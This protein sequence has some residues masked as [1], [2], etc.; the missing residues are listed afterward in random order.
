MSIRDG[1]TLRSLRTGEF[2]PRGGPT[3]VGVRAQALAHFSPVSS[4]AQFFTIRSSAQP[5]L[6]ALTLLFWYSSS[7]MC[8]HSRFILGPPLF[9]P[10]PRGFGA[11]LWCACGE[12]GKQGPTPHFMI[13]R[14]PTWGQPASIPRGGGL[15]W[16]RPL[17]EGEPGRQVGPI[18]QRRQSTQRGAT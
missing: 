2:V 14:G 15:L 9:V 13:A 12:R 10:P 17:Q 3:L 8:P 7:Q 4:R 18:W 16:Q 6:D 11:A 5:N 1:A